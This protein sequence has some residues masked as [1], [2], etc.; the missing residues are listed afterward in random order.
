MNGNSQANTLVQ[1]LVLTMIATA[2]FAGATTV[3]FS[4]SAGK[5]WELTEFQKGLIGPAKHEMV[6][7]DFSGR[8]NTDVQFIADRLAILNQ[9]T[10]YAY[11][12]DEGRWNEWYELFAPDVVFETTTPCIGSVTIKGK[13]AMKAMTDLRY[14]AGGKTTAVRR[15]TMGNVHVAEQTATTAKVRSYMLISSVPAS[16]KL[17]MLTTGTYNAN[18]EKRKGAWVITRWY[19][20]SD[21][22]LAPSPMPTNVPAGAVTLIPDTRPECA[23]K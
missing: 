17:N 14:L 20:E 21:A 11:L 22:Q 16:D 23:K 15:H 7:A 19:I 1:R 5:G 13:E 6:Q 3:V 12:I 2:A 8:V 18:M 10:A 9:M 4:Q